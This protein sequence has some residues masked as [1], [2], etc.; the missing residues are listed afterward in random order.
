LPFGGDV[1]FNTPLIGWLIG[2]S[3]RACNLGD[4]LNKIWFYKTLDG[5]R[6]WEL[7]LLQRPTEMKLA[8]IA[9][10]LRPQFFND[11]Q[12]VVSVYFEQENMSYIYTTI[13]GG[14]EWKA[15]GH[16]IGYDPQFS[17]TMHGSIMAP[18]LGDNIM[19]ITEDGGKKW[20]KQE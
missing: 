2:G 13:D 18:D 3:N 14:T 6:N 17:N 8:S 16:V 1:Y 19:R 20:E 11:K 5:G 9:G 4:E 7:V 15:M 12:G 10:A